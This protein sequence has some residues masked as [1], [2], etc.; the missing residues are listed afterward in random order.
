M[1]QHA[2]RTAAEHRLTALVTIDMDA[3]WGRTMNRS[4][5][6]CPAQFGA[7]GDGPGGFANMTKSGNLVIPLVGP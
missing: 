2:R 4:G 7:V 3:E 5:Y 6:L 1:T